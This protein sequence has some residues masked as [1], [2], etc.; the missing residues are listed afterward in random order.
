MS[1]NPFCSRSLT[2]SLNRMPSK[3][4]FAAFC[5]FYAKQRQRHKD[6]LSDRGWDP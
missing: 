3:L 2:S 5:G 6:P 1:L 4:S